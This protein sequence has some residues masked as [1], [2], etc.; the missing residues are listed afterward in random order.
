VS[1]YKLGKKIV[2]R[3]IITPDWVPVPGKPYLWRHKDGRLKNAQPDPPR[4]PSDLW[5]EY[6][7]K[8]I[9][10]AQEQLDQS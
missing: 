3:E 10:S 7:R 2:E 1:D 6:L 5:A 8:Q 9:E 4:S